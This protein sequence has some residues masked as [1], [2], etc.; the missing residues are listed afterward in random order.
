MRPTRIRGTLMLKK[1]GIYEGTPYEKRR[2]NTVH[3]IICM[4]DVTTESKSF[5]ACIISTDGPNEGR[6][7]L[8]MSKNHFVE[9]D[10]NGNFYKIRFNNTHLIKK[11]LE[12]DISWIN[13]NK[14]GLLTKEGLDFVLEHAPNFGI[15]IYSDKPIWEI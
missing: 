1:G 15:T 14:V 3:Y 5:Q 2:K 6:D 13:P 9:K 4:E 10:A 12:K 11:N 8:L 7:N